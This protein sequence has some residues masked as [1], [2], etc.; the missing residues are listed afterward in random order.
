MVSPSA[1][2]RRNSG[3]V[4]QSPT[5]FAFAI[6][7]RGAHS[8]VRIT[9]TG[10]PDCTSIVSSSFKVCKVA[11]I[12]SNEFQSRAAFPV[13]PYTTRSSGRSATA[14]SRLFISIRIAASCGQPLQDSSDPCGAWISRLIPLLRSFEL[15]DP[16][17]D[18]GDER[19]RPDKLLGGA[20]LRREPAVGAEAGDRFAQ[21][22]A[23]GGRPGGGLVRAQ[24]QP[25][26]RAGD[27]H[28]ED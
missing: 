15:P 3:H 11:T 4:A 6:S 20:E 23:R 16:L 21:A 22:V 7:T 2:S 19:P 5:R 14:G 18:G 8:C 24:L 25:A 27:L 13:P 28:R 10:R 17:L 1:S 12:A 26:H 9:P